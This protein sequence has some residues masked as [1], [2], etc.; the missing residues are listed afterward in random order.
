[1]ANGRAGVAV[2]PFVK[3]VLSCA[4][5][6]NKT[7]EMISVRCSRELAKASFDSPESKPR[8]QNRDLG[9]PLNGGDDTDAA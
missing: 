1:M 4:G 5:Q 8:S 2:Y 9:H 3:H 7:T 6:R